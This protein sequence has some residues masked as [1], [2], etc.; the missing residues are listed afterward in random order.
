MKNVLNDKNMLRDVLMHLKDLMTTHGMAVKESDCPNMRKL[1]TKLSG[2]IEGQQF[3]LFEYM[4]KN[5]LYPVENATAAYTKQILASH[6]K[7]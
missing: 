7:C 6:C 2:M 5:G 4:N 3:M 1:C